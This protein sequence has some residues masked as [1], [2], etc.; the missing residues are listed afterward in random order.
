MNTKQKSKQR[1]RDTGQFLKTGACPECGTHGPH[2]KN[3]CRL[4]GSEL[5]PH[6]RPDAPKPASKVMVMMLD[7]EGLP[8]AYGVAPTVE[9]A[10]E[11]A[12]QQLAIYRK[13]KL[14]VEDH[15]LA[16]A[17]YTERLELLNEEG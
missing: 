7:P 10:R 4:C 17:T 9:R 13:K 5:P 14:E 16:T 15:Y 12:Q 2:E 11:I 8:R 6:L 1:A 3:F